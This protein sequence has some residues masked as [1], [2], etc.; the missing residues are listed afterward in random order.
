MYCIAPPWQAAAEAARQAAEGSCTRCV[1]LG[2]GR[3]QGDFAAAWGA[4]HSLKTCSSGLKAC[5]CLTPHSAW[6]QHF[7]RSPAAHGGM[8]CWVPTLRSCIKFLAASVQRFPACARCCSTLPMGSWSMT[9][10]ACSPSFSAFC[11]IS[12]AGQPAEAVSNSWCI[13]MM[14]AARFMLG[15][16]KQAEQ[17]GLQPSHRC[18]AL[19]SALHC[20]LH[21]KYRQATAQTTLSPCT[22]SS[23]SIWSPTCLLASAPQHAATALAPAI[24][25]DAA[26]QPHADHLSVDLHRQGRL[27][28]LGQ[29]G[30][31]EAGSHCCCMVPLAG[32]AH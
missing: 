31:W 17:C 22:A 1:K 15:S 6:Q 13:L 30:L 9:I 29:R 2:M 7:N 8:Y 25:L 26:Q 32:D 14:A 20:C 16:A 4:R 11:R 23:P 12:T 5:W 10:S 27:E 3:R 19:W 18:V 24:R 28:H 21:S